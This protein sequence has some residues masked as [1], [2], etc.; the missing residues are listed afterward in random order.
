MVHWQWICYSDKKI[1]PLLII[2]DLM[3][4]EMDGFELL[5]KIAADSTLK[6]IPTLVLTARVE[7]ESRLKALNLGA[8]D[9]II[10]PF[11]SQVLLHTVVHLVR[12]YLVQVQAELETVQ[13]EANE[14]EMDAW[15]LELKEVV[16][17][18]LAADHFSVDQLAAMML[19]GRTA[20]YHQVR[21][22]TGMTPNQLILEARLQ[23]ARKLLLENSRLTVKEVVKAVGFKHEPHFIDIFHKRFGYTPG[24]MK[25]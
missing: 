3:M 13:E 1:K 6:K 7:D 16:E 4:P 5:S 24:Q 15:V 22:S 19:M 25:K 21:K 12:R 23:R 10:K 20:F 18:H 9:Y 8:S 2:T 11:D 14:A 17:H